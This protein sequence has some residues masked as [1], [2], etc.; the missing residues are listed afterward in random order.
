MKYAAT[1]IPSRI[2]ISDET[3][4]FQATIKFANGTEIIRYMDAPA[5]RQWNPNDDAILCRAY[6]TLMI[7]LNNG[8]NVLFD[9]AVSEGLLRHLRLINEYYNTVYNYQDKLC[10]LVNVVAREEVPVG[11]PHLSKKSVIAFSGG[12]DASFSLLQHKLGLCGASNTDITTALVINGLEIVSGDHEKYQRINAK[13]KETLN[14]FDVE[15]VEIFMPPEEINSFNY[16]WNLCGAMHLFANTPDEIVYGLVGSAGGSWNNEHTYLEEPPITV[17]NF[18]SRA[19]QVFTDGENFTR[20]Q[21]CKLIATNPVL[22][23]NLRVCF[24]SDGSNGLNCGRCPKCVRTAINFIAN[25]VHDLP[26]LAHVPDSKDLRKRLSKMIKK[27]E[28]ALHY[29]FWQDVYEN[30][31]P[32]MKNEN[33]I[34]CVGRALRLRSLK[35]ALRL[36]ISPNNEKSIT[37]NVN[38][39]IIRNLPEQKNAI[40]YY[41]QRR[42]EAGLDT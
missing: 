34:M 31:N 24:D 26:F 13:L 41:Q 4:R 2:K 30:A 9:G 27:S 42:T 14:H 33:L 7:Y 39:K 21:K 6:T 18:A 36:L 40:R 38:L 17:N 16:M 20:M 15:M 19:F 8:D 29:V 35:S 32:V 1:V 10:H 23:Q 5:N 25:D 12:V 37:S 11:A 3:I 28:D 22:M